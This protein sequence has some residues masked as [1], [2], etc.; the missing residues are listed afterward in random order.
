M[1]KNAKGK[2]YHSI[3]E[4]S[5][6]TGIKPYVLRFWEKEF[7]NLRPKKNRAG[8]RSYQQ[9]DIEL[10]NQIKYLLYN[11]GYTIEG[12]R[13]KLKNY[14]NKNKKVTALKEKEKIKLKS[15]LSDVKR[16]LEEILK[17]F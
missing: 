5:K 3:S 1:P 13:S 7:P 4:V 10:I 9:K 17:L 16:E 11:E 6:T 12:A 15:V 8:N 14:R 2:L